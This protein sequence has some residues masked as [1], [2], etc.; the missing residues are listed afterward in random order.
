MGFTSPAPGFE[1][2]LVVLQLRGWVQ[3]GGIK[4]QS[5]AGKW[6]LGTNDAQDAKHDRK[7]L[8][9]SV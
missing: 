6:S 8:P 4:D 3:K 1:M 7:D 9:F 5:F 2:S